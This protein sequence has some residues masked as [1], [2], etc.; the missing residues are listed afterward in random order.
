MVA[1]AKLKAEVVGARVVV[2]V[3]VETSK[4]GIWLR[5]WGWW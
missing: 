3:T 2:V 4:G 1:S 5:S